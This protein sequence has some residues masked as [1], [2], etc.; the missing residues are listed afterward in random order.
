MDCGDAWTLS[1]CSSSFFFFFSFLFFLW[2]WLLIQSGG[3]HS[4]TLIGMPANLA[5]E[6][7][8]KTPKMVLLRA[9]ESESVSFPLVF[10]GPPSSTSHV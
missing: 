5:R 3:R 4:G 1:I 10:L 9:R 8:D 6:T 7:V 2:P